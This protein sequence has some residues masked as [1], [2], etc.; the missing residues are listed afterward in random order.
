MHLYSGKMAHFNASLKDNLI[1]FRPQL[2]TYS[3]ALAYS[4]YENRHF[5]FLRMRSLEMAIGYGRY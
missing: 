5:N 2:V 1:R 3:S 4:F